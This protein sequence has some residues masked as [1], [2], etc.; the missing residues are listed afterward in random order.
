MKHL[1][2]PFRRFSQHTLSDSRPTSA[3]SALIKT[4]LLIVFIQSEQCRLVICENQ[5]WSVVM[6]MFGLITCSVPSKMKSE[7]LQTLAAFA[8][9]AEIASTL[10]QTLET[11]QVGTEFAPVLV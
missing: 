7:L 5:Q 3:V 1:K 2:S 4:V 9:T 11:S 8:R 6:L 10:W